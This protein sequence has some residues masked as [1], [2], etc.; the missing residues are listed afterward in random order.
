MQRLACSRC[1]ARTVGAGGTGSGKPEGA[2]RVPGE[3]RTG[4]RDGTACTPASVC[5]GPSPGTSLQTSLWGMGLN[6]D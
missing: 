1:S 5:L 4:T 6:S 2:D 3:G